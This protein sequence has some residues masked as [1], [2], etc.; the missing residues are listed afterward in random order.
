MN[1][2]DWKGREYTPQDFEPRKRPS[3]LLEIIAFTLMYGVPF[4]ICYL[5][6]TGLSSLLQ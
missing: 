4:S 5:I 2:K 1:E 3:V 6:V